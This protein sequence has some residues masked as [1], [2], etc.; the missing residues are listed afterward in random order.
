MNKYKYYILLYIHYVYDLYLYQ[1]WQ[2]FNKPGRL[3]L[4][5]LWYVKFLYVSVYSIVCFP[6]VLFHIFTKTNEKWKQFWKEFD[7]FIKEEFKK[8]KE[9]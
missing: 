6:L 1:D 4:K 7:D 3:F 8:M 5:L 9:N 2:E